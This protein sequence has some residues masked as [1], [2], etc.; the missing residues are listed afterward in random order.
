MK[1]V[2]EV[3]VVAFLESILLDAKRVVN[4]LEINHKYGVTDVYDLMVAKGNVDAIERKIQIIKEE[5]FTA[6]SL[7]FTTGIA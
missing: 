5:S 4:L 1:V 3:M 7:Y 6:S 2:A